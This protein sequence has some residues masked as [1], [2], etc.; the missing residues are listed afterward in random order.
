M[1]GASTHCKAPSSRSQELKG[2]LGHLLSH[3]GGSSS[4]CHFLSSSA[5][6][7]AMRP[8]VEKTRGLNA[9]GASGWLL[10]AVRAMLSRK[11]SALLVM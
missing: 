2:E 5:V 6:A 9:P 1:R 7:L 8:P 3:T 10:F 11:L 4:P